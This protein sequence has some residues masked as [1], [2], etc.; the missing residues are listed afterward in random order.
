MKTYL[1]SA[2][3]LMSVMGAQA[4]TTAPAKAAT[5][6]MTMTQDARCMQVLVNCVINGVPM[7]MMLDTGATNTVLHT[8]SLAKL[9]NPRQLDTS[10][11]QFRGNAKERPEVYLLNLRFAGSAALHSHP[12]MV[13]NLDG[14]RCMMAEQIDG[15][16]GMDILGAMPFTFDVSGGKLHWGLPEGDVK[17]VPLYGRLEESGRLIMSIE[18][19]GKKHEILLDSGSTVTRIPASAWPAGSGHKIQLSVSDVN[20]AGALYATVGA[21]G[22]IKLAPGVVVEGVTPVFCEE[23][24]CT[25]LG[26]DVLGRVRLVHV[27]SSSHP[28]GCFFIAL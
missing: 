28:T 11:V 2:L 19:D 8:G 16:I 18:C 24:E 25:I 9:K 26:M 21:P 14:A 5:D 15:I 7:R 17:L 12:V 4:E 20:E 23:D 27:P 13:L 3:M 6:T 22:T 1:I 10:N